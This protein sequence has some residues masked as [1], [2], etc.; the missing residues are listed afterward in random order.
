[1]EVAAMSEPSN[2][3]S[4]VKPGDSRQQDLKRYDSLTV[5]LVLVEFMYWMALVLGPLPLAIG[6]LIVI[7]LPSV[8][9]TS[10]SVGIASMF[11]CLISVA[12]LYWLR[13]RLNTERDEVKR[14]LQRP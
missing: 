11:L 10:D 12:P 5:S 9:V 7:F 3:R 4:T 8:R 13:R 1:M 2:E 6:L 14:R